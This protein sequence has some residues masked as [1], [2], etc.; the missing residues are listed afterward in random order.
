MADLY[1]WIGKGRKDGHDFLVCTPIFDAEGKQV[2]ADERW[3]A[4]GE[5]FAPTPSMLAS[6]PDLLEKVD[7]TVIVE[8]AVR[9]SVGSGATTEAGGRRGRPSEG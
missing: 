3:I 1:R 5:V 8:T 7:S 2:G 6:F 9:E 4:R